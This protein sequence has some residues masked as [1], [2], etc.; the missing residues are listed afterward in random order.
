MARARMTPESPEP[1]EDDLCLLS[2]LR[3]DSRKSVQK[4]LE[5]LRNHLRG[6]RGERKRLLG[7][8]AVEADLRRRG[9]GPVCG[10]DEAGRGPLAGP[11]V[12]AAVILHEPLLLRGMDDSKRMTHLDRER[13][14]ERLIQEPS[15]SIGVGIVSHRVIDRVNILNATML[16]MREA[17]AE[18][19][20]RPAHALVDGLTVRGLNLPQTKI[21]G[22]DGRCAAIACASIIAKVTRDRMMA[23]IGCRLPEWDF[24]LHK[25]YGTGDHLSR[26]R[27]RGPSVIHRLTFGGVKEHKR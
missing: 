1:G 8:F 19:P 7:L 21:I 16:A 25:G 12:A 4:L 10:I 3:D 20:V 24:H 14:F 11:V 22:G 13:I 18:L 9:I 23:A 27:E 6:V 15:V 17:V 5:G 26:I 2:A